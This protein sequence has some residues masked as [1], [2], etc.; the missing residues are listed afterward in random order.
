VEYHDIF[1][2]SGDTLTCTTAAQHAIPTPTID[3]SRAINGKS[4][5]IPEIHKEVKRPIEQ[6]FHDDKFNPA[7]VNGILQF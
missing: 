3:P 1:H 5:R 6:T 4:Y 7:Q 2:L